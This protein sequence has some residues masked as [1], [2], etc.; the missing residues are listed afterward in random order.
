VLP[1]VC[2]C[3][4]QDVGTSAELAGEFPCIIP[5]EHDDFCPS[6]NKVTSIQS[7]TAMGDCDIPVRGEKRRRDRAADLSSPAQN[8]CMSF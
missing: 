2:G 6:L 1:V 8:E 5:I 3:I 4:D 7:A